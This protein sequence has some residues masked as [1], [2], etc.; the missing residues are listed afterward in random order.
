MDRARHLR[1][2]DLHSWSGLA[3][4]L[5][6]YVI[7]F[8]GSIALF[9][10]EILSWED[11]A[12][13]MTVADA[14]VAMNDTFVEWVRSNSDKQ[15]VQFARFTFP[16]TYEPYFVGGMTVEDENG[17][18][19]FIEQRWDT[20]SGEALPE[21]GDGLSEWL[22]DFHRDLMWPEGLGGRTAGRTIVGIIGIV[23]MLSILTGVIA[24]TKIFQ[25][26][27][28]LRYLR[29]VRLKWQDTHK[30]LGLW[31]LP[32]YTMI[33][34]TGAFLG[35]VAILSPLVALLT[36]K[37]DQ[38][39]LIAAV[40]GEP[41]EATGEAAEMI[42][43]D[44]LKNLSLSDSDAPVWFVVMNHYGDANARFDVYFK[45][46]TELTSV[47]GFQIDGVSGARIE[48][49]SLENLTAAN[50]V[51]N[52]LSP[53]HYGTYG[54]IALKFVYLALGLSLSVITALGLMMWVE[55]RLHGS[56]GDRSQSV[57]R[58]IGRIATGA[59][60]GLPLA[61]AALFIH[62]KLY[63]GPESARLF[64]TGATYFG[65][66]AVPIA[67]AFL[68]RNDYG[69]TREILALTGA[70]LVGAPFVNT[71]VT[72]ASLF[73][74]FSGS[75]RVAG[76]VDVTLLL[77]GAITI[78][79]ASQLP[80]RRA[81]ETRGRIVTAPDGVTQDDAVQGN[82]AIDGQTKLAVPAE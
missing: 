81:A 69:V 75:H 72:G 47:E 33:A 77:L 82:A 44:A 32:F 74:A 13:R 79:I 73:D 39:A 76:F 3:L 65:I 12:K 57:Y 50:R 29:S 10:H 55:R 49:S 31:G 17:K 26:L 71:T 8:S 41:L 53:L 38:E 28:T 21:R 14:P 45:P 68:R 25:E 56:T 61:T 66:W 24:H 63:A 70:I 34:F 48:D 42:S 78:L 59:T 58:L 54:G 67:Y 60:A 9:H 37:G 36:F 64:W 19:E 43:V 40:L 27:F 35:V 15:T 20:A 30:V 1:N 62:D 7:C 22:L 6:V 80:A 4:G 23:L 5:F 2:Y 46:D 18:S 51:I 52:A 16:T 11:P